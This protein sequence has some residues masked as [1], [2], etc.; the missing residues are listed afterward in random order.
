MSFPLADVCRTALFSALL[1]TTALP[2]HAAD[3]DARLDGDGIVK[4]KSG[5][6]FDETVRPRCSCS[7]IRHGARFL[8]S[9][10]FAAVYL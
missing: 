8:R 1:V 3:T 6:S 7:A 2:A 5:Y 10:A 9:A 4:V